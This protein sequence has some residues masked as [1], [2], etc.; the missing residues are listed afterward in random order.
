MTTSYNVSLVLLRLCGFLFLSLG[1]LGLVFV[2]L[3]I[4]LYS[5]GAPEWF[6]QIVAPQAVQSA[7]I[8]PA[9]I[10]WGCILF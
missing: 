10:L 1:V 6:S 8:A 4:F 9:W 5:L 2:V 3:V 7:L